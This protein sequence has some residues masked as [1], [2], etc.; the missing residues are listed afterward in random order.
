MHRIFEINQYYLDLV[1]DICNET[2]DIDY[3]RNLYKL[4]LDDANYII[5]F[6]KLMYTNTAL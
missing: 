3:Y 5:F 2:Y 4:L 6:K 1:L